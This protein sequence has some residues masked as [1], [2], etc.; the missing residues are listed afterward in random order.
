MASVQPVLNI[1]NQP[2]TVLPE[3]NS[4]RGM[5]VE[6]TV[7]FVDLILAN[8]PARGPWLEASQVPRI[9]YSQVVW[10]DDI[11]TTSDGKI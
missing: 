10:V 5:W 1:P 11:R 2:V 8:P 9:Y 4:E 7:P 3:K 6:V